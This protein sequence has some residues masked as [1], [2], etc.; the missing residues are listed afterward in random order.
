MNNDSEII[1]YRT[2]DGD[3]KIDAQF[4]DGNVWLSQAQMV[5]LFQT[6]KQNISLHINNI[7]KEGELDPLSTVKDYLTV[8]PEGTR[9]INR[10]VKHYNLDVIIAVG[11]RVKSLCGTHFRQWATPILHE[12]L[13]KGFKINA[14]LLK[15]A[16]GGGYW[17]ELLDT[18]RDIRSSEKVFYRQ[19]LDIYATS[20]D[21]DP[22]A[23]VSQLFFQ[24]VQNKMH[25]AAHGHTAA[26]IIML[27]ANA[28]SPFMGMTSFDGTK[29]RKSDVVIA[30]N[31]LQKDE[32][33]MLNRIVSAYLEFA[34][35]QAVRRVPMTM[36]DWIVRL[37]DFIKVDGSMLLENAGSVSHIEAVVKAHIEYDKYREKTKDELSPAELDFLDN[38]KNTQKQLKEK[39]SIRP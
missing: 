15:K 12:Y 19:V 39:L 28:E 22:K 36:K 4:S 20:I 29:P 26:E 32:I 24:T 6:T 37:D 1:I 13:Q 8:Q 17:R 25:Y 18:I 31:Y 34:E 30:K 5:D 11:Y 14:D 7:F 3:T 2:A 23:E 35:I 16:G 10:N 9:L 27:R 38:I 33:E 21:Y